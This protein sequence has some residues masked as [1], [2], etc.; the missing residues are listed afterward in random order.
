MF[1]VQ[2]INCMQYSET[3]VI[4]TQPQSRNETEHLVQK[5]KNNIS[6]NWKEAIWSLTKKKETRKRER[7]AD[8]IIT[9]DS[10]NR[11]KV[12]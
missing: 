12:E 7:K 8:R 1:N 9:L 3:V 4:Q 10:E 11:K 2:T 6:F 5:H